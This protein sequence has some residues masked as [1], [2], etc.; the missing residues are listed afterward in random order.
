MND[1]EPR[2]YS[3]RWPVGGECY[4]DRVTTRN[5]PRHLP[6]ALPIIGFTV[7]SVAAVAIG[8]LS[9]ANRWFWVMA[10]TWACAAIA[11]S[12]VIAV[13]ES[14]LASARDRAQ[15]RVKLQSAAARALAE[16]GTLE[17]TAQRIL[18]AVCLT[19]KFP[20]GAAW[21]VDGADK[22]LRLA[23]VW[24]APVIDAREFIADSRTVEF[25]PGQGML[26]EV[27]A[28]GQPVVISNIHD[29][30]DQFR[31]GDLL[32]KL[33]LRSVLFVPVVS[34]GET[35][36]VLECFG[37]DRLWSDDELM[38]QLGDIGRQIG[39]A[40]D[41]ANRV[42]AMDELEGQRRFVLGALLNAE[43]NANARLASDLHDDTIQVLVATILSLQRMRAA[44]VRGDMEKVQVA[45]VK[46]ESALLN[47]TERARHIMFTL[48]PEALDAQG[49]R[50]A[51]I[52]LLQDASQTAGFVF[53]VEGDARRHRPLEQLAYRILQEAITNI[54]KHAH[55]RRVTVTIT[56]DD[57]AVT[58]DV[59]DDGVG[60]DIVAADDRNLMRLHIGLAS[61]R[62]RVAVAGGTLDVE[63][64]PEQGTRI[65]FSIPHTAVAND[66]PAAVAT[67]D[68]G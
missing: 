53:T 46:A 68:R 2:P 33:G 59:E 64:A 61:M 43:E 29:H 62:E 41:R 25:V 15:M 3:G 17:E 63:T 60:F 42:T 39:V 27:W 52:A 47:A 10:A 67:G 26:G 4:G 55:A 65:R 38:E 35:I 37:S 45:A 18:E 36:G 31:R 23:G 66:I 21:R 56:D 32:D 58:C 49:L 50:A 48:R 57:D 19:F 6:S 5:L 16:A 14:M 30:H 8:G 44:I 13:R 24:R 12:A 7:A 54:R 20:L 22:R 28:T 34:L 40:F 1:L 9:G 11:A 51:V